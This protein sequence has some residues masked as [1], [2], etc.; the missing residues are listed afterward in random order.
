MLEFDN[1]LLENYCKT[2]EEMF[3]AISKILKKSKRMIKGNFL[4]L[5]PKSNEDKIRYTSYK[6]INQV[7]K[8]IKSIK[9][10]V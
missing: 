10:G 4:V 8:H 2:K 9:L 6:Y 7:S 3:L 1:F 5:N